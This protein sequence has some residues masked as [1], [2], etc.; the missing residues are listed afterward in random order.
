VKIQFTVLK[1][2]DTSKFT[3]DTSKRVKHI[4]TGTFRL[5]VMTDIK[6]QDVILINDIQ[7]I[8]GKSTD[9]LRYDDVGPTTYHMHTTYL[10]CILT[11]YASSAVS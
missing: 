6:C 8:F 4:I 10:L 5:G 1:I 9:V 7:V 3:K 2:E 11:Y